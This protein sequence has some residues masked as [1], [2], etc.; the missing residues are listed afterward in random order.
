MITPIETLETLFPRQTAFASV[1]RGE[2]LPALLYENWQLESI[3]GTTLS[4]LGAMPVIAH[5]AVASDIAFDYFRKAG[6]EPPSALELYGSHDEAISLAQRFAQN[7]LRLASIYPPL[8][9][10]RSFDKSL[11]APEVYDYLN[12]KRN[13]AALC[14]PAFV[15][16]RRIFSLTEAEKLQSDD[17]HFPAFVKG[18]LAGANGGG[19]DVYYCRTA[20]DFD[21]A[22]QWFRSKP[23]FTGLVVEEPIAIRSNWC[24]NFSVLDNAVRYFG[25]AEQVFEAVAKQ[26]GSVIDPQNPPPAQAIEIGQEICRSAQA[27]GFRGV[28]GMDMCVDEA[29]KIYFFDLNF[30]IN[31]CTSLILLHEGLMR[32]TSRHSQPVS[33]MHTFILPGRLSDLMMS[34]DEMIQRGEF[35]PL[36]LYD[37]SMFDG[38]SAPCRITGFFRSATRVEGKALVEQARTRLSNA[39][40]RLRIGV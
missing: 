35:V 40:H 29:G 33:S 11:V 39:T 19:R 5:R 17:F 9:E 8:R 3:T 31:S 26:S 21:A 16:P 22:L 30:R 13:L 4:C 6:L 25:A 1:S 15:P 12:D 14:P 27:L 28:A 23:F 10:I 38:P 37:G 36:Q 24:L 32:D 2:D 20:Q 7:G 34:L 18:A